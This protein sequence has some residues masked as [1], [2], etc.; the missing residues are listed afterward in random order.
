MVHVERGLN[1]PQLP[2]RKRV[3]VDFVSSR[4]NMSYVHL[5]KE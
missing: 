4:I 5:R 2:V 3:V 1:I